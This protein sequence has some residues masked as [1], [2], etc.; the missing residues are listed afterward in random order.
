[1]SPFPLVISSICSASG[2]RVGV[3]IAMIIIIQLGP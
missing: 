1:M 2:V 3:A